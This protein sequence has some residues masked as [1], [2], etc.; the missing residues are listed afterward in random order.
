MPSSAIQNIEVDREMETPLSLIIVFYQ[1]A[2]ILFPISKLDVP[3]PS[4]APTH[5]TLPASGSFCLSGQSNTLVKT[6]W[7]GTKFG[8][9]DTHDDVS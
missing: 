5:S 6:G 3:K 9:L 4:T 7:I 8:N 2:A 1:P